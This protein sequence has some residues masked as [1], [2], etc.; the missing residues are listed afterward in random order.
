M[1]LGKAEIITNG[2]D[3]TII[4]IGKT[5]S[6]AYE[7]SQILS[8]S[9]I[10]AEVINTRFLK[11]LDTKTITNSITKTKKVIVLED[12]TKIGG[13]SSSIKELMIDS[14]LNNIKIKC[15]TYPDKFIDHGTIGQ[16]EKK[17][18]IDNET[19][20]NDIKKDLIFRIKDNI[21]K[22]VKLHE[23]K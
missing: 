4:G 20:I 22:E 19:I 9:N 21:K 17:Y 13:L 16:L 12:G 6:K 1:N 23:K 2:K 5:V 18:H 10:K 14:Q 11:P 8:Q 3:I 15:Y 7:I